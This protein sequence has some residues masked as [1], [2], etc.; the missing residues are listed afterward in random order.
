MKV[1]KENISRLSH[2]Y[3]STYFYEL[4]KNN[5]KELLWIIGAICIDPDACDSELYSDLGEKFNMANKRNYLIDYV[6]NIPIKLSADVICGYKQ[7]MAICQDDYLK[8][9]KVYESIRENINLHFVWPKH[10]VPTINTLRYVKYKDRIDYLLYD[11]KQYFMGETTLMKLAY[12]KEE[13]G[14]WLSQFVNFKNFI[15]NMKLNKF[16]DNEYNVY[17]FC[18][19]DIDKKTNKTIDKFSQVHFSV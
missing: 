11:L 15:D 8:S 9:L 12:E 1:Y 18:Y 10:K 14:L 13:T 16:V 19:F 4:L 2:F 5:K 6:D 7:I 3:E 17:D